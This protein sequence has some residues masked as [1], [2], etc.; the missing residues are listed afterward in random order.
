MAKLYLGTKLQELGEVS[1]LDPTDKIVIVQPKDEG[2]M[3]L[4]EFF[5]YVQTNLDLS[6]YFTTVQA[7]A[8]FAEK[9]LVY[10]KVEADAKYAIIDR[11]Y[12]KVQSDTKYSIK[13]D[14]YTKVQSD[15]QFATLNTTYLRTELYNK[16]ETFSTFALKTE[17][18]ILPDL[19]PYSTTARGDLRWAMK[20]DTFGKI[21]SDARFAPMDRSYDKTAADGRFAK[22][23]TTYTKLETDARFIDVTEG[24]DRTFIQNNIYFKPELY[25]KL[26]TDTRFALKSNV[27]TIA[28]INDQFA[29]KSWVYSRG[30]AE[31][32]FAPLLTTFTKT[33]V[34]TLIAAATTPIVTNVAQNYYTKTTSD[35][36]YATQALTYSRLVS[37]GKY[38]LISNTLTA[39]QLIDKYFDKVQVNG[40]IAAIDWTPYLTKA[41]AATTYATLA[42]TISKSTMETVYYTRAQVDDAIRAA[43]QGLTV[44]SDA[45]YITAGFADGRYSNINSVYTKVEADAKYSTIALTYSVIATDA[46]FPTKVAT[47]A[48]IAASK[49]AITDETASKYLPLTLA[50]STYITIAAALAKYADKTTVFTKTEADIRFAPMLRSY[51]KEETDGRYFKNADPLI[52][53]TA[54][55]DTGVGT[56]LRFTNTSETNLEAGRVTWNNANYEL[57][58]VKV[59]NT[60]GNVAE[61]TIQLRPNYTTL[62]V[63]ALKVTSDYMEH[64]VYGRLDTFFAKA[65]E[66]YTRIATDNLLNVIRSASLTIDSA[67][68]TY[69]TIANHNVLDTK[70]NTL[71]G[72]VTADRLYSDT[73]F[74]PKTSVY[75]K[76]EADNKYLIKADGLITVS[77]SSTNPRD[78]GLKLVNSNTA[79]PNGQAIQQYIGPKHISEIYSTLTGEVGAYE[80]GLRFTDGVVTRALSVTPT[81]IWHAAYGNLDAFFAKASQVY[82]KVEADAKFASSADAVYTKAQTDTKFGLKT[83]LTALTSRV[84]VTEGIAT[85]VTADIA[86]N[87]HNKTNSYAKSEVDAKFYSNVTN[88]I[89]IS[90]TPGL[91]DPL[92]V[93][94]ANPAGNTNLG[95]SYWTRGAE[96]YSLNVML[97]LA[98]QPKLKFASIVSGNSTSVFEVTNEAIWHKVYGNLESYFAKT[99]DV[100]NTAAADAKVAA[101]ISTV[102]TKPELDVKVNEV[103]ARKYNKTETYSRTEADAK[104]PL[105]TGVHTKA[106]SDGR[107]HQVSNGVLNVE[108]GV[109]GTGYVSGIKMNRTLAGAIEGSTVLWAI[110]NKSIAMLWANSTGDAGL[111][112]LN[113]YVNNASGE[114]VHAFTVAHTGLNHLAY[115][116]LHTYFALASNSYTRAQVYTKSETFAK[117][118]TYNRT[119]MDT[120]YAPFNNVYSIGYV[121]ATF[122][123]KALTWSRAEADAKFTA[124]AD[125]YSKVETDGRYVYK[126]DIVGDAKLLAP[127]T[128]RE[129][130]ITTVSGPTMT[131]GWWTI[132][133]GS[134]VGMAS[135]VLTDN[136]ASSHVTIDFSVMINYSLTPSIVINNASSYAAVATLIPKI[137]LAYGGNESSFVVRIL[138][139]K[140]LTALTITMKENRGPQAMR[141]LPVPAARGTTAPT[142]AAE[143]A[144]ITT[145]LINITQSEILNVTAA[146]GIASS[147]PINSHMF[148]GASSATDMQRCS[149]HKDEIEFR[150]PDGTPAITIK[151]SFDGGY[152]SIQLYNAVGG[153]WTR[154]MGVDQNGIW[155]P[156]YGSLHTYFAK[157]GDAYTKTQSDN[158]YRLTDATQL[159]ITSNNASTYQAGLILE[160]PHKENSSIVWTRSEV[161]TAMWFVDGGGA[162]EEAS[163]FLF[164]KKE[165][166]ALSYTMHV[167]AA[168]ISH[169]TY[170]ALHNYFALAGNVY[171]KASSDERYVYKSD[172]TNFLRR[173]GKIQIS[174]MA[175]VEAGWHT[176]AASIGADLRGTFHIRT[177]A[178]RVNGSSIGTMTFTVGGSYGKEP[179]VTVLNSSFFSE[180]DYISNIQVV[181]GGTYDGYIVRMNL[182][183]DSGV[184]ITIKMTDDFSNTGVRLLNAAVPINTGEEA[185]A[186]LPVV[187]NNLNKTV[188]ISVSAL[189]GGVTSNYN[190]SSKGFIVNQ[191]DGTG[192][193]IQWKMWNEDIG[194]LSAA[195]TTNTNLNWHGK[196]GG[197]WSHIF[198]VSPHSMWHRSYGNL[199]DYFMKSGE[200]YTKGQSDSNYYT[201]A[202]MDWRI[203]VADTRSTNAPPEWYIT[204]YS[205]GVI[206][207]FK[208]APSIGLSVGSTY[209]MLTTKIQY[210]DNSGGHPTQSVQTS[211]NRLFLRTG[212][213]STTWSP[214]VELDTVNAATARSYTKS[215]VDG[216]FAPLNR[217]Y[218]KAETDQAYAPMNRAYTKAESDGR[219]EYRGTSYSAGVSDNRYEYKS[220]AYTKVQSDTKYASYAQL[221]ERA[222]TSWVN[223]YFATA[224]QMT[225]LT[226]RVKELERRFGY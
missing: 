150:G 129:N 146:G 175:S 72:R 137:Q 5:Y 73:T 115:G 152:T 86:A 23:V 81:N 172:M 214:W 11:T 158:R 204:L 196:V 162:G 132:A 136:T 161:M 144:L 26:E 1:S 142:I 194:R 125:N 225:S 37:D 145:P 108:T 43:E 52:A 20:N 105:K 159:K 205:T 218:T 226:A 27:Y 91:T 6:N 65:G 122:A 110:R 188:T 101:A 130:A 116:D 138:L 82:T 135:F 22:M 39:T 97:P 35:A 117:T 30:D 147:R 223:Q 53:L 160:N 10:S 211:E 19:S 120:R 113:T 209:V 224:S 201:K 203:R 139:G 165:N 78:A 54:A 83:D 185:S 84:T 21:E 71:D 94:F 219:F 153:V 163:M 85:S 198:Q 154:A 178:G 210:P 47:T 3:A 62:P 166:A 181:Y 63:T 42:G 89:V 114:F 100:Y 104:Y 193:D 151:P 17:I 15:N 57:G 109:P 87:Y 167:N 206:R 141:L 149:L 79:S 25:T 212:I 9:A 90:V 221:N 134:G 98:N 75:T 179:V 77:A 133:E 156:T 16:D 180:S 66:Y 187:R 28:A 38:A 184:A 143:Q 222:P 60:A 50:A 14:T 182:S 74:A 34:N 217:S 119:E 13:E 2:V 7:N 186:I 177:S 106:E 169:N 80:L 24:Y 208:S 18:P 96:T 61:F 41:A 118:E 127:F 183:G 103:D 216:I 199:N 49:T 48:E 40:L 140:T 174:Q 164:T 51:T 36:T 207:E 121:D 33:E 44:D 58:H 148:V 107:Y 29:S 55:L 213:N 128:R 45:R 173:D 99:T 88:D 197:S 124:K 4:S 155:H 64:S 68:S 70:V 157:T 76:A 195:D 92:A 102:Y 59:S 191:T 190:V 131:A 111:S 176:I 220:V 189:S 93:K 95:G 170:G 46:K 202:Y 171:S 192:G 168:G 69:Q 215:E 123:T 112:T 32:T 12:T 67:R 200:S 31:S 126:S 8:R 56:H